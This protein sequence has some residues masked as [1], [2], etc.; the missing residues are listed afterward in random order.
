LKTSKV[1][2]VFLLAGL[3]AAALLGGIAGYRLKR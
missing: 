1:L 3:P 2:K